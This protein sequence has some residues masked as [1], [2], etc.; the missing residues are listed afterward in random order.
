MPATYHVH[1][2]AYIQVGTG[3][4]DALETLGMSKDGIR[5][6]IETKHR[7]HMGDAAG[8][9]VPSVIQQMG[10]EA[11]IDI[12]LFAFDDA[13]LAKCRRRAEA[14]ATEGVAG[15]PGQVLDATYTHKLYIPSATDLPWNFPVAILQNAQ[16]EK[17][18]TELKVPKLTFY[19]Y[20]LIA[21]TDLT[22]VNKVLYTR[23]A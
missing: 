5:I 12:D 16:E 2:P 7:K 10:S 9:E 13:V 1:G 23:A 14:S 17:P 3:T 20:R 21:P 15:I 19:A 22:A 4:A 11:F 8:P 18:G 6:R